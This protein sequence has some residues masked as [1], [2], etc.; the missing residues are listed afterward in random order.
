[1]G[2]IRQILKVMVC[3][4]NFLKQPFNDYTILL[5]SEQVSRIDSILNAETAWS[6]FCDDISLSSSENIN[7]PRY[8]RL[9][10][11]LGYDAPSLDDT[12]RLSTLQID[13]EKILRS[14]A[15]SKEIDD[16]ASRLIASLFYYERKTG[17]RHN[18]DNYISCLGN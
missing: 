9:N 12:K 11:D 5:T 13:T 17:P 15:I 10:P 8:I 1:M 7:K 6:D 2:R 3:F 4:D 18:K 16:I 14:P